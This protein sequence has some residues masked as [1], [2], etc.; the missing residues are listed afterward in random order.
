MQRHLL[1]EPNGLSIMPELLGCCDGKTAKTE[2][3]D[4]GIC[5]APD[6]DAASGTFTSATEATKPPRGHNAMN[7]ELPP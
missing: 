6:Y 1:H 4:T 3:S 5:R 2:F 7:K